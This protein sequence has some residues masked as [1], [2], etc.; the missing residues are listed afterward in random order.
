MAL[1]SAEFADEFDA[2]L[3]L[4]VPAYDDL[5]AAERDDIKDGFMTALAESLKVW[6]AGGTGESG[7]WPGAS[8]TFAAGDFGGTDSS[9]DAPDNITAADGKVI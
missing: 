7:T 2:Q 3:A 1:S 4:I 5:S 6:L 8:V 9:G